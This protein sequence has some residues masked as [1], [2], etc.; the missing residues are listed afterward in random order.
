MATM[1]KRLGRVLLTIIVGVYIALI[2][3]ALSS[4]SIIFQPQPSSYTDASL[5]TSLAKSFPAG[6]VLHLASGGQKIT[7][8][9]LPNPDAR[10]TLLFSHG[11]AEDIGETLF[12]L[13]SFYNTGFSVMAYDYRGYGTS[14]G[15]PSEQGVYED[16]NAAYDYLTRELHIPAN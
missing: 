12:F 4:D 14:T 10:Y 7:T 6:Q 1:T 2:V 9:Y 3:L 13:N 16:V 11:N 5:T 15:K 8:I